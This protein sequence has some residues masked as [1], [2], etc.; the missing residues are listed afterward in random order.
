MTYNP[1][2]AYRY[3]DNFVL[4]VSPFL[5]LIIIWSIHHTLLLALGAFSNSGQVL[6]AA[7]DYA[8]SA[9]LLVSDIPGAMVLVARMNRSPDAGEKIRWLWR[10]GVKFLVLGLSI[11]AVATLNT[12]RQEVTDP[13][14]PAFWIVA[15]TLGFIAYL[16]LSRRVREIFADFP[17]P[18][19]VV[20]DSKSAVN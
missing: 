15:A 17:S 9:P 1:F 16:L 4:R 6:G 20:E 11:S 14:N 2:D 7:V 3:D 13:E 19:Q 12:Y 5:W 18:T 8:A 10:H